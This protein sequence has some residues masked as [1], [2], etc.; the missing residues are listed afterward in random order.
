MGCRRQKE[1]GVFL[2]F[3]CVS[4][5]AFLFF[6]DTLPYHNPFLNHFVMWVQMRF[7]AQ[8]IK[9]YIAK[10]W[11]CLSLRKKKNQPVCHCLMFQWWSVFILSVAECNHDN[12]S[13]TRRLFL[14]LHKHLLILFCSFPPLSHIWSSSL[15]LLLMS[16][17]VSFILIWKLWSLVQIFRWD[18]LYWNT[19]TSWSDQIPPVTNKYLYL[20]NV[21]LFIFRYVTCNICSTNA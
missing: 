8:W 9:H 4:E 5:S 11:F 3:F 7:I 6:F 15:C 13:T 14:Y 16:V 1:S 2:S 19:I 12:S 20:C 17:C 21:P 10:I 18:F